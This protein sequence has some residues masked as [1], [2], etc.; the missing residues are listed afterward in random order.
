[1]AISQVACAANSSFAVL[2]ASPDS[3]DASDELYSWGS[4]SNGVLGLKST[5]QS[6]VSFP[7]KVEFPED[8]NGKPMRIGSLSIG[9]NHGALLTTAHSV[10]FWGDNASGQLGL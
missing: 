8:S 9:D 7:S 1:M 6:M 5:Q 3:Q 10:Y 4:S 2:K